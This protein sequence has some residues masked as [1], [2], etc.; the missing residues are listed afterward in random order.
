MPP[1]IIDD[2]LGCVTGAIIRLGTKSV[3]NAASE[4]PSAGDLS[5]SVK[6]AVGP[7]GGARFYQAF[8]RN[9]APAFCPP[10]TTN[11][12]NGVVISWSP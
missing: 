12:T 1:T 3:S 10:A 9:A 8:Y 7:A 11:R 5:V 2:G 4:Y 6:G